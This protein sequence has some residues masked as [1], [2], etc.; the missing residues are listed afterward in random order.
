MSTA[1][2]NIFR[3]IKQ[4]KELR[5]LLADS[6]DYNFGK[7]EVYPVH[8]CFTDESCFP[9]RKE[10]AHHKKV[11]S[12]PRLLVNQREKMAYLLDCPNC[13]GT[14]CKLQNA[15][16]YLIKDGEDYYAFIAVK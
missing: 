11:N 4:G 8:I 15:N 16:E 3:M 10:T 9:Y 2:R 13:M 12:E 1:I 6:E 14:K 7:I 5:I